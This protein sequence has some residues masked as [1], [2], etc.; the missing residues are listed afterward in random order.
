[1]TVTV[2]PDRDREVL[3]SFARRID[4]SDAGAHNNLGVLYF[5]RSM[6]PEAVASFTRALELDPKMAVA[7][8]NL[9]IAYRSSGFYDRRMTEL[10][11]RLRR[12][13]ADRDARWELGRAFAA[14]GQYEEA[15]AE[16]TTL[17]SHDPRDLGAL[18]QLGLIEHRLGNLEAALEWYERARELDPE[19]SVLEFRRGEVLY[20][21]G[22]I[23]AALTALERAVALNPDHA[24]AHHL[25]AFVLGDLGQHTV[26]RAAA[27][28]AAR[29]NP[30]L[31]RAEANLS[32]EAK[33]A[34]RRSART[35]RVSGARYA[36]DDSRLAHYH[37]ARAFRQKGY[38][39]DALREYR[40]ALERGEDR[41]LV[42]SAMAEVH[43]VRRDLPS[44]LELYDELVAEDPGS[45]KFWNERGVSLHQCGRRDEAK[46]SYQRALQEDPQYAPAANNLAV[47]LASEG[48]V[49][50]ALEAFRDALR[51]RDDL[52]AT[53]LNL[54]LLLSQQRRYQLAL[55]AYRH[56]LEL[57]PQSSLAWNGVGLVL[58]ELQRYADARN[59]F[60]RAVEADPE[61]AAAHYNLSFS[62]SHLGDFEAA[63]REVKQALERDPYYVPPRFMLAI[64]LPEGDPALAMV[65]DLSGEQQVRE[66]AEGFEFD[67]RLV[68][69]LFA[70]LK[71]SAAAPAARPRTSEDPFQLV[72]DYV[73][74][75]LF[76]QALAEI[77]RALGRGADPAEASALS[78]DVFERRGLHGEALERYREARALAPQHV[79]ARMGEVRCLLALDRA[80]QAAPLAAELL[81]DL[82]DD[83][84]VALL[85]AEAKSR[86][87]DP[88]G[89]L[90]LLQRAQ[91]R[92][93]ERADVRK[94]L[95]DVARSVGDVELAREAYRTALALDP[96]YVEV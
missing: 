80:A 66:G 93:P 58:V 70:E 25:L 12:T 11:E 60:G 71:P 84:D 31:A 13:P 38:Y 67:S 49:D 7:Q 83:V 87:G 64:E 18:M 76:D 37:L 57:A 92:S 42:R 50:A 26:A 30:V 19:S 22:A 82:A 14:V 91:T 74:K 28:R 17:L 54:A 75:S 89:A 59:A 46:A 79:R 62:L 45:G 90:E 81:G 69:S 24:E 41:R 61:S 6:Y 20:N 68:D 35:A 96:G 63:L 21:R 48:Q 86:T 47:A 36:V 3:V 5:R 95:G 15:V 52:L 16:F 56:A 1:M 94:L 53:R 51:R 34:G 33:E 72:R 55:E 44:A 88:A 32:L 27:R 43:L 77:G 65:P 23:D 73:S 10:R 78:A 4:P 29:L 2:A 85:A 40:M 9:E 8:R 39:L